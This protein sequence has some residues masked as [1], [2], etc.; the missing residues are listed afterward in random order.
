MLDQKLIRENPTFVQQSLSLRGKDFNIS[1]IHKLT[2]D[3]KEIDIEI[4]SLQ[5]ESKKLS[6]TIGIEIK[7]NN[8]FDSE[9]L[10]KLKEKGNLFKIKISDF[11]AKKRSLDKQIQDEISRL[12]NIPSNDAPFGENESNNLQVLT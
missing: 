10:K 6:K 11:E 1:H 12:P 3:K 5:S 9:E 8:N 4:S 2:I 7:N